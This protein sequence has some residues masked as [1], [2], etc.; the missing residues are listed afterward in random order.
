MI[1]IWLRKAVLTCR[2]FKEPDAPWPEDLAAS[3]WH[4]GHGGPFPPPR[5]CDLRYLAGSGVGGFQPVYRRR[6]PASWNTS[7][8]GGLAAVKLSG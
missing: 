1:Y 2:S 6:C 3:L 8:F 5:R 4:T 7:H